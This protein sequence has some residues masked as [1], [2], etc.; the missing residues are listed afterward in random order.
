[1]S[2]FTEQAQGALLLL[3][4]TQEFAY[5]YYYNDTY[6]VHSFLPQLAGQTVFQGTENDPLAAVLRVAPESAQ[7]ALDIAETQR[8]CASARS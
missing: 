1:M 3:A 2:T 6:K 5:S 8:A 4:L 7:P